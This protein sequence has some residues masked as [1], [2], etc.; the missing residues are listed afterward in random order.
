MAETDLSDTSDDDDQLKT[1]AQ[2]SRDTRARS[3]AEEEAAAQKLVAE[4][5]KQD[6]HR[7]I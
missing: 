3:R 2:K 6:P 4:T 7:S 1:A 5:G